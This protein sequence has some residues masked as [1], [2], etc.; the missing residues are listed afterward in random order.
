MSHSDYRNDRRQF[1]LA[2]LGVAAAALAAPSWLQAAE[3]AKLK[4]GVVGSG[5]VGSALGGAW[6]KT[7][8][9]VMFSSTKIENDKTLAASLGP[10]ALAGTPR[11]AAQF[12][13]VLL[14]SVPFSALA[15][16]GKELGDLLKGKIVIDTCNAYERRDGE[17]A[18]AALEKGI[19][20]ANAELLPGARTVRAFNAIG[21][22]R[23]GTGL[24]DSVHLGIPI[25]GQD[26]Q[27]TATVSALIREIGFE[28]VSV[29][30]SLANQLRPDTPLAGEH[31]PE[32][33]RNIVA[34]LK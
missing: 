18:K 28:P 27:A 31:T 7:G 26:E 3:P 17:I 29:G 20:Y 23:M 10:N 15:A 1:L 24:Q 6:I 32:E 22:F 25:A 34:T 12:A 5:K 30:W 2:G 21:A 4:I 11:E 14:I 9:Q 16:V 19:A 33:L 13:D 8:H